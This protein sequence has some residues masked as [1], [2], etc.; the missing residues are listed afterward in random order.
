MTRSR[1]SLARFALASRLYFSFS[2]PS[3]WPETGY[4]LPYRRIPSVCKMAKAQ[5]SLFAALLVVVQEV[6]DLLNN[7]ESDIPE[8]A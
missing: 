5:S 4:I 1:S 2:P 8:K 6:S 3:D 7:P